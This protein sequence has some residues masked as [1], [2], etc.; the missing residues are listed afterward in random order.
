MNEN[1]FEFEGKKYQ[2][3]DDCGNLCDGCA[4]HNKEACGESYY[5]AVPKCDDSDRDDGRSVIFV[6]KQL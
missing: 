2:A 5:H 1:E 3:I 6:E 4:F